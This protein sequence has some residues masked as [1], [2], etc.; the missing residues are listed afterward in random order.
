MSAY[1]PAVMMAWRIAADCCDESIAPSHVLLG[2]LRLC[3]MSESELEEHLPFDPAARGQIAREAKAVRGRFDALGLDARELFEGIHQA[4]PR[5]AGD[6]GEVIYIHRTPAS[7]EMFVRAYRIS[8]SRRVPKMELRDLLF[9]TLEA[10][11]GII[12]QALS[13]V[14]CTEPLRAFFGLESQVRLRACAPAA[15]ATAKSAP[16]SPKDKRSPTP[17]LDRYGRD[18]TALAEGGELAPAIAREREIN[19][20]GRILSQARK[21]SAVLLGEAGVGKTAIAEGLALWAAS[22]DAPARIANLRIVEISISSLLAGTIWRGQFEERIEAVIDE[23]IE[24]DTVLFIDELHT[25]V[26]AG[27]DGASNAANILKPALARGELRVIGATT[28]TEYRRTIERDA[29]LQRRFEAIVVDEP[30]PEEAT[31]MLAG[32]RDRLERHHDVTIPDASI[33]AAVRLAIRYLPDHRLPDKALDVLDHACALARTAEAGTSPPVTAESVARAVAE[34]CGVPLRQLTEDESERLRRLEQRLSERVLGQDAAV[35]AVA[36]AI[37]TQRLGIGDPRR[38]AG[39]FL[40]V[41]PTGSGKTELA[42][43]LADVWFGDEHRLLRIDMSEYMEPQSLARLIGAPPGYVGYGDEG[44]LTGPMRTNPYRVVLLDEIEK[45][46]PRV[47]DLLL[48]VLDEGCLTD[49]LGRRA[50]FRDSIV[51]MTSNLGTQFG[52]SH[53]PFGFVVTQ[54]G[55]AEMAG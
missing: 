31:I 9:A 44:Q 22:P 37:R 53:A 23:A 30:A 42:K 16:R 17:T 7:R 39:A 19:S 25:I 2:I 50:S 52:P 6:G 26:G 29:A 24:S 28:L 32:Q 4:R 51:I 3:L 5:S 18:L 14:G 48:Q 11:D 55:R 40:F 43:V 8:A 54:L 12:E 35:R 15:A 46:H 45:A 49:G 38:P 41:G 13:A 34:R 10:R 27:G 33:E 21:R 47:L 20:L 1:G 36:A